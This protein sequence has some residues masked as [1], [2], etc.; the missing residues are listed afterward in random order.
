M[1]VHVHLQCIG[2]AIDSG[3]AKIKAIPILSGQLKGK[4]SEEMEKG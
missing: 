3:S 4:P 2:T 1:L